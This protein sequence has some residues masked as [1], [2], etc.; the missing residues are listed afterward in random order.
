MA[1]PNTVRKELIRLGIVYGK[2]QDGEA[3]EICVEEWS[4]ALRDI[5]DE[6]FLAALGT[7]KNRCQFFPT[8]ADV[9]RAYEEQ[10]R[11]VP[12][13]QS[14]IWQKGTSVKRGRLFSALT[15]AA[16]AKNSH[17]AYRLA[18]E[19]R[20]DGVAEQIIN[21]ILDMHAA[22]TRGDVCQQADIARYVAVQLGAPLGGY[23]KAFYERLEA[24]MVHVPEAQ[25]EYEQALGAW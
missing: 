5:S 6:H 1:M 13:Q 20:R 7:V 2:A 22:K 17:E 19:L 21:P 9:R 10:S 4:K 8:P 3:F 12:Q 24:N 14:G 11:S 25:P 15:Q 23:V 16:L 18:E